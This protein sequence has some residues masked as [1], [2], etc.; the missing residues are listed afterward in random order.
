MRINKWILR[1]NVFKKANKDVC[2][3]LRVDEPEQSFLKAN[4]IHIL[5]IMKDREVDQVLE[6]LSINNRLG[7]K[8]YMKDPQ[9]PSSRS[10][11]IRHIDLY[12]ALPVDLK[13]MKIESVKRKLKKHDVVFEE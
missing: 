4:T 13:A 1:E 10:A 2:A 7:S 11:L 12:N 5:K 6:K 9:K 3:K 8:I